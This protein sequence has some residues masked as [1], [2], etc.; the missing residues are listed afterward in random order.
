[1]VSPALVDSAPLRLCR[2]ASGSN[3]DVTNRCTI[4]T[5]FQTY[6][7]GR[8][9]SAETISPVRCRRNRLR[10]HL[11]LEMFPATYWPSIC[12][13]DETHHPTHTFFL[14]IRR[15]QQIQT[16]LRSANVCPPI[17]RK[18]PRQDRRCAARG[19]FPCL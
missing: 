14:I 12:R 16:P 8:T 10:Q 17:S 18:L 11:S 5:H 15:A 4:P 1:M 13:R 19:N 6:R 7:K 3:Q 2:P 9:Y